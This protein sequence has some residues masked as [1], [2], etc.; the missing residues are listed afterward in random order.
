MKQKSKHS[1]SRR[2]FLATTSTLAAATAFGAAD[3]DADK[4]QNRKPPVV[5]FTKHL[6][7]LGY[8]ELAEQMAEMGYDGADLTVRPR[9]HVLPENVERDLPKA[10]EA[11]RK[12]GLEVSM[13]TTDI[14]SADDQWTEPILKTTS[15]MGITLYRIG[16]WHYASGVDIMPQLR[17]WNNRLKALAELNAKYHITAVYHNHSGKRYIG[18]PIWDINLMLRDIDPDLIG[19]NYDIG[20]AFLEGSAGAWETNFQLLAPKIRSSAV[21]DCAWFKTDKGW[22]SE[23]VPFGDGFVDWN[24][25]LTLMKNIGFSGP[26][27]MHFEYDIP[28]G[29]TDKE[30]TANHVKVYK[31]D[32]QALRE[33]MKKVGWV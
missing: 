31:R 20:H 21:K 16:G 12:A 7:W 28:S 17:E 2:S 32:L 15:Q 26:F 25:A 24:L 9:G 27:S 23:F 33:E 30:K 8:E 14:S 5:F 22:K 3:T 18:G 10:V 6:G 29:N 19:S 4:Q 1:L 11:I 13:I